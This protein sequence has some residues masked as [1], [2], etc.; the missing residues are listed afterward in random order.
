[1]SLIVAAPPDPP[2]W[3][4]LVS[5]AP[6]VGLDWFGFA[7]NWPLLHRFR[8]RYRLAHVCTGLKTSGYGST[9]ASGYDALTR[10]FLSWSLFELYLKL[11]SIKGAPTVAALLVAHG[12]Q[13]LLDR[14]KNVPA[15]EK[16]FGTVEE[17]L[18][19]R[20]HREAVAKFRAGRSCDPGTVLGSVRHVFAHGFLTPNAGGIAPTDAT[21]I[22]NE[23]TDFLLRLVDAAWKKKIEGGFADLH[24]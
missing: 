16:F 13:G 5:A 17:N 2:H 8:A 14:I 7:N 1:M 4:D 15:Y 24:P 23:M 18:D 21:T 10:S 9:T 22:C 20:K 11:G 6:Y 19:S 3:Q 12:A